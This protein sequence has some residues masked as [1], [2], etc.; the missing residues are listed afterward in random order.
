MHSKLHWVPYRYVITNHLFL[1][2]LLFR[3]E[4][5]E[6]QVGDIFVRRKANS[7]WV[8]AL[9]S[10]FEITGDFL[11]WCTIVTLNISLRNLRSLMIKPGSCFKKYWQAN[12]WPTK[13]IVLILH[14]KRSYKRC[15]VYSWICSPDLN[16]V[17]FMPSHLTVKWEVLRLRLRIW[18]KGYQ[19]LTWILY[20]WRIE[21]LIHLF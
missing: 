15:N 3:T 1:L 17:L 8:P 9:N 18:N 21:V 2:M 13:M 19:V 7:R 11:S 5:V 4:W 14:H 16:H 10:L 20:T 12:S 6:T